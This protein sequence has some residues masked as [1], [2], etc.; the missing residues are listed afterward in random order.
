MKKKLLLTLASV[1]CA[2]GCALGLSACNFG[3]NKPQMLTFAL[4]DDGESYSV[5]F[6]HYFDFNST[7]DIVIP[8]TYQNQPV[9]RIADNDHGFPTAA[10]NA[11]KVTIPESVTEIDAY[12]FGG[13]T[14]LTGV[15]IPSK[16]T[17]IK[18]YTFASCEK[19]TSIDI[20]DSVESI[21]ECAFY[22]CYGLESVAIGSSVK[23]IGKG[24][25]YHSGLTSVDIPDS[26]ETIGD[27]AFARCSGLKNL[28]I[29]RGLQSI[30]V[31]SNS[32][33]EPAFF[34]NAIETAEIPAIACTALMHDP[35][36]VS[37]LKSVVI[38]S[39][40]EI[41]D[42]AFNNFDLLASVEIADGIT[43]IGDN[44]FGYCS[45]LKSIKIPGSVTSISATAFY[46]SAIETAELPASA[47]T[48][49]IAT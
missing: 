14:A 18:E 1:V 38:T 41:S 19:L 29:G 17:A 4:N 27:G 25:F 12:A 7:T 35:T 20:P 31:D 3:G 28:K 33:M 6:N 24:S 21:G 39:G 15:N 37:S 32:G 16:V 13:C 36:T 5:S 40:D 11:F 46:N 34:E 9:T 8:S 45:S 2:L 47:C 26:V 43:K 23:S 30:G 42:Y 10:N 48:S 44:A 49:N 22:E